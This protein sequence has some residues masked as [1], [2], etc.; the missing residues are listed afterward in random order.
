LSVHRSV[1]NISDSGSLHDVANHKL[2]DGFILGAS[3]AAVSTTDI[4]DMSTAMLGTSIILPL[5]SHVS[6]PLF[7]GFNSEKEV[8]S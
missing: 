1:R 2:S 5:L 7:G 6:E 8:V 4:L 3:L